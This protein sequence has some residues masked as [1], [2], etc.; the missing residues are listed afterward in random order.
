MKHRIALGAAAAATA[1]FAV[2]S[3]AGAAT[4]CTYDS[5]ART[6]T[7]TL[8]APAGQPAT[9]GTDLSG[10]IYTVRDGSGTSRTCAAPGNPT[11]VA[12]ILSIDS[13]RINGNP[14]AS[15]WIKLDGHNAGF[16]GQFAPGAT[17][18]AT[19]RSEIEVSISS[20]AGDFLQVVGT[21]SAD[22]MS[23]SGGSLAMLDLNNDGDQDVSTLAPQ[24]VEIDGGSGTDHLFGISTGG[25]Q[26]SYPLVLDG[27]TGADTIVGGSGRD[28]LAGG[29]GSDADF[30]SS[31]D[32]A[33]DILAGQDGFD[34]AVADTLDT[35]TGVESLSRRA[36]GIL[37]EA[38]HTLE[39]DASGDVTLP[40]RWTHPKAWRSL[41][42]IQARL[43]DG[44]E[45]VGRV[46]IRPASGRITGTGA[47]RGVGG[48][49]SHKGKTVSARLALHLPRSLQGRTLRVDIRATDAEGHTQLEAAARA[50]EA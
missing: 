37:G 17:K 5:Q 41:K 31:V 35:V 50:I 38:K 46:T 29:I 18:E 21:P 25:I 44:A 42:T 1:L 43:Y 2:P 27:G 24:R 39:A 33:Q 8:G 40:L 28:V 3:F 12:S 4:T 15:E 16:Q 6:A 34:S 23:A 36:V 13:I 26:A 14:N 32:N 22:S 10:Q 49:V 19:G 30:L 45:S 9:L 11:F 47:A 48:K 7:V 20:G